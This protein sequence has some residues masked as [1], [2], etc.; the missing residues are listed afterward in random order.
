MIYD[1]FGT[2]NSY[3][4]WSETARQVLVRL[5]TALSASL[6]CMVFYTPTPTATIHMLGLR[7]RFRFKGEHTAE[8]IAHHCSYPRCKNS[9]GSP[10]LGTPSLASGSRPSLCRTNKSGRRRRRSCGRSRC[11]NSD[12]CRPLAL[13]CAAA[14]SKGHQ[15]TQHVRT[16]RRPVQCGS[17]P[18]GA[19][20]HEF[21]RR[22][23]V[24]QRLMGA[25]SRRRGGIFVCAT[26]NVHVKRVERSAPSGSKTLLPRSW[27]LGRVVLG[28][29]ATAVL[30]RKQ[31]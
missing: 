22:R 12:S 3:F 4:A 7:W 10:G 16:S 28:A 25:Q 13:Q 29:P 27:R 2:Q 31:F 24:H 17:T 20:G 9:L 8:G 15:H 6:R 26:C 14:P 18:P 1:F 5:A 11:M 23:N 19:S 30:R 21:G